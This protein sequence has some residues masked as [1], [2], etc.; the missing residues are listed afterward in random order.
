[1]ERMNITLPLKEFTY[2]NKRT[3]ECYKFKRMM[4]RKKKAKLKNAIIKSTTTLAGIIGFLAAL[5]GSS[6]TC[7]EY[8]WFVYLIVEIIAFSYVLLVVKANKKNIDAA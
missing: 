5:A 3:G 2:V 4:N 8:Y 7:G 1:M 6:E